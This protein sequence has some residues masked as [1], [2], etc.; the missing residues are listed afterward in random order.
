MTDRYQIASCVSCAKPV[1][2]DD[3]KAIFLFFRRT[4]KDGE[5]DA[6]YVHGGKC[7]DKYNDV[8]ESEDED[9]AAK[10]TKA[11]PKKG[12]ARSAA[13]AV[14]APK[15][16]P[17][18]AAPAPT[19]APVEAKPTQTPQ[20]PE[21]VIDISVLDT[22]IAEP[23]VLPDGSWLVPYEHKKPEI[24]DHFIIESLGGNAYFEAAVLR[25]AQL[26]MQE[27]AIQ[28]ALNTTKVDLVAMMS[29]S[30]AKAVAV[31][32]FKVQI[33]SKQQPALKKELLLQNGVTPEQIEKSTTYSLV[34][35]PL[36]DDMAKPATKAQKDWAERQDQ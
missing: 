34:E 16:N 15:K 3:M 18:P 20:P 11:S 6:V 8:D 31:G 22:Q 24:P 10:K 28:K 5:P 19:P 1:Y 12:P 32:R 17:T 21:E 23:Q 26:K 13:A 14:A 25:H 2:A 29:A 9:M 7:E 36:V 27:K 35:Y 33:V 30:G 4:D